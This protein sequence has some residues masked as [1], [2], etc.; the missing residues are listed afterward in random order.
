VDPKF[1]YVKYEER[2][3]R[4][5]ISETDPMGGQSSAVIISGN[6][7]ISIPYGCFLL[8][9]RVLVRDISSLTGRYTKNPVGACW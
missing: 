6:I 3:D 9:D 5:Q 7:Q 2:M 4:D 1:I 8:A